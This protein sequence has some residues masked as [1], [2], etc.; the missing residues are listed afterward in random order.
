[1]Y[2][3]KIFIS[4][5]VLVVLVLLE[6]ISCKHVPLHEMAPQWQRHMQEH[7]FTV[8]FFFNSNFR[9]LARNLIT[10]M[11]TVGLK[12]EIAGTANVADC[13]ALEKELQDPDLLC[14]T[15]EHE[16][17]KDFDTDLLWK[18][19]VQLRWYFSLQTVR[20]GNHLLWID[21]DVV[22]T[23]DP[24]PTILALAKTVDAAT[25]VHKG[26]ELNTGIGYIKPSKLGV[27]L[28]QETWDRIVEETNHSIA[29]L[30]AHLYDQRIFTDA[31]QTKLGDTFSRRLSRDAYNKTKADNGELDTNS[32]SLLLMQESIAKRRRVSYK[33]FSYVTVEN[34]IF[35]WKETL[36]EIYKNARER[37]SPPTL[38]ELPAV[39]HIRE[40]VGGHLDE[41]VRLMQML[42]MWY[43]GDFAGEHRNIDKGA[44]KVLLN[45]TGR[46]DP[47]ALAEMIITKCEQAK[48][49]RQI[50]VFPTIDCSV[51]NSV[52]VYNYPHLDQMECYMNEGYKNI[53]HKH[54]DFKEKCGSVHLKPFEV[55]DF[56]FDNRVPKQ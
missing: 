55:P 11:R 31:L 27:A 2:A 14:S 19:T 44:T 45:F 37:G 25:N 41:K 12:N 8:V 47:E 30:E 9:V 3:S 21:M 49:D 43:D 20:A 1:M 22:F 52:T 6:T 5:Y 38:Y 39:V 34:T 56:D 28:M 4:L 32:S 13:E 16:R 53:G 42:Q 23:R 35:G 17:H 51:P 10:N 36:Y 33:D 46:E 40:F 54:S 18:S 15:I 24:G 7:G 50:L 48:E 26:D 29:K